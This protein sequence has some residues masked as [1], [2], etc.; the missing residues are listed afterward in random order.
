M[1]PLHWN[2]RQVR[3]CEEVIPCEVH[4]VARVKAFNPWVEEAPCP[5]DPARLA[6]H[7]PTHCLEGSRIGCIIQQLRMRYFH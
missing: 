5:A 4:V 1:Y 2:F 3:V 7:L 6:K